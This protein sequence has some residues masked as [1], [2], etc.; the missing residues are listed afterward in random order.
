MKQVDKFFDRQNA[1]L[2]IMSKRHNKN[3]KKLGSISERTMRRNNSIQ[4]KRSIYLATD[5]P[6]DFTQFPNSHPNYILYGSP[7]RSHSADLKMRKTYNS[8]NNAIIDV[9]ALSMTDFLVCTFSSN[10]CR[11]A[12]ELMQTHHMELGDATQ[13]C[14]SID[15][16]FHEEDYSRLKFDVI[17]PDMKEQLKYGDVLDI[18]IN[19]RNGSASLKLNQSIKQKYT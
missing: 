4:I 16:A 3:H 7:G 8:W 9:I 15:I 12:Y 17:I 11:L 13:L 5:D 19:H 18:F 1:S 10:I 2:L 14:H 6:N